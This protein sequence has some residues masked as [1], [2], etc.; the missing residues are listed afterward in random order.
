[1]ITVAENGSLEM[2]GV[3]FVEAQDI[4]SYTT[5]EGVTWLSIR[6]V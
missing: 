1:M 3:E 2:T 5:Q 4:R 6:L